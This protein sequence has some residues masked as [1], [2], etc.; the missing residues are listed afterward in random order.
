[1]PKHEEKKMIDRSNKPRE[2]TKYQELIELRDKERER[3]ASSSVCVNGRALPLEVNPQGMLKWYMHPAI[4]STAH[5][6]LIF[7]TQEIPPAS[8]SGKQRSQGGVVF[9]VVEG[10]GY[11]VIDEQRYEWK[12]NDVLQLPIK[13]DGVTFQHF[14][15]SEKEPALLIAAEPNLTATTGVDRACGFEQLEAAPEYEA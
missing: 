4:D 2:L 15:A 10:T 6:F 8:R 1:M 9:V 13:P 12:K 7:Y 5:K 14:N 3:I 11:T